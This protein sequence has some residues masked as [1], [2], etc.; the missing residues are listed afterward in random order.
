MNDASEPAWAHDPRA[1]RGRRVVV[2]GLGVQSGGLGVAAYMREQGADLVV[3]D[4]R[5]EAQLASSVAALG[6]AGVRYVLGRHEMDDFRHAEVVVRNPAVRDDSRYLRA[7]REAGAHIEMEFTLF[8]R[9]CRQARV[10][11]VTGTRGKTTTATALHAMLA[12]G[13]Q[14]ALL[15]GNMRVSALAQLHEIEPGSTVVLELSSAQLEGLAGTGLRTRGAIVTNL[16]ADHLDRYGDMRAYAEAKLPLVANQRPGDWAVIPAGSEW[17]DWFAAQAG[18]TVM[19]PDL[20]DAPPGWGDSPLSGRHNRTNLVLAAAAARRVGVG[21][22][23]IEWAVRD[24]GGVPARQELVGTVG[25]VR[26]YND[27]T[28]TTPEA[29]LAAL[30][31]V[32]GPWVLIAGGSDKR[33]DFTP[34]AQRLLTME[35]LR[36]VVLLPGTGTDRL[37]PLLEG[38]RIEAAADM[39]QAVDQALAL[40]RWGDAVLL[41]PACASFGLFS[42][43][44]DRGDQ[45]VAR[46]RDRGLRPDPGSSCG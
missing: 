19:R 44:F 14:Q 2:M 36:G 33:L 11:G 16:M 45:F 43:E 46:L 30:A 31:T 35:G 28:A 37:R 7:A 27:T 6:S 12:A 25:G 15:A 8:L 41:S 38:R 22:D 18:G 4:L 5:S 34:L 13:G 32:P 40:A 26:A 42:N 1:L 29:A 17:P 20:E 21:D 23:A 3:T 10:I 39:A 24:F 9:W